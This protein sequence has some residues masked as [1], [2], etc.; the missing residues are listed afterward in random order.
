M[1]LPFQVG[2]IVIQLLKEKLIKESA[3]SDSLLKEVELYN[4][5]L[6]VVH[7]AKCED[8]W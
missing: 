8:L 6:S 1:D 3:Y 4:V 2:C 5:F 7:L